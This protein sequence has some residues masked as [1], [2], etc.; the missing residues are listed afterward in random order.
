[1]KKTGIK[2]LMNRWPKCGFQNKGSFINEHLPFVHTEIVFENKY[3]IDDIIEWI[4]NPEEREKWDFDISSYKIIQQ[5]GLNKE[6]VHTV[7]NDISIDILSRDFIE[8][9]LMFYTPNSDLQQVYIT[10]SSSVSDSILYPE[11]DITRWETLFHLVI[12]EP[13]LNG[14]NI[15]Q[16]YT[17]INPNLTEITLLSMKRF[18][19]RR[20]IKWWSSLKKYLDTYKILK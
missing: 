2:L 9:K 1:M 12:Y 7:Y 13:Q 3:S 18:I 19:N 16:S 4:N 5:V 10:L 20:F 17:Q 15:I 6:I 11:K 14:T 8:N